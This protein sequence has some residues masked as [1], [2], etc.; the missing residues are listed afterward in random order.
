MQTDKER[1]KVAAFYYGK[2]A[3]I[4]AGAASK[5][6]QARHFGDSYWCDFTGSD[7]DAPTKFVGSIEYRIKPETVMHK[8]GEIPKPCDDIGSETVLYCP[9]WAIDDDDDSM[10]VAYF[11][12]FSIASSSREAITAAVRAGLFHTTKEAAIAHAKVIYQIEG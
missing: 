2:A 8:G 9:D 7:E 3:E 12:K 4:G 10:L 1:F 6:I 5:L 11:R